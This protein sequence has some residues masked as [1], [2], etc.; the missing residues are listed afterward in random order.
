[1]KKYLLAAALVL[2]ATS[3]MADRV[4]SATHDGRNMP[5]ACGLAKDEAVVDYSRLFNEYVTRFSRCTCNDEGY[6]KAT[7]NVDVT[8]T[9]NDR[10]PRMVSGTEDMGNEA[11]ACKFAKQKAASKARSNEQVVKYSECACVRDKDGATC[12]VNALLEKEH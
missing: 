3:A 8:L 4:V 1:M 5:W 9:K 12:N 10:V 7:C 6:G 2:V 11:M